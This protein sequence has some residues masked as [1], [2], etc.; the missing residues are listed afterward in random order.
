LKHVQFLWGIG[1]MS[2]RENSY[3]W[4]IG[5]NQGGD[6]IPVFFFFSFLKK[7]LKLE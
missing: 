3:Y 1:K 2:V 5:K 6:E 7:N 4:F